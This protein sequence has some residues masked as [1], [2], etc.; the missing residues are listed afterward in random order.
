MSNTSAL[1]LCMETATPTPVRL[2]GFGFSWRRAV[3]LRKTPI[4]RVGFPWISL[5]S[6]VRIE[7]YQWVTRDK[8]PKVFLALY[9]AS[10]APERRLTIFAGARAGWSMGASLIDFLIFC[11]QTVRAALFCRLSQKR[12]A[13]DANWLGAS[14]RQKS[15]SQ[16][17]KSDLAICSRTSPAAFHRNIQMD[18]SQI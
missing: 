8:S 16:P 13:S 10:A 1:R 17:S 9:R 18:I 3:S 6:L 15:K 12:H 4:I 2:I 14:G 7:T 11:N 5:D